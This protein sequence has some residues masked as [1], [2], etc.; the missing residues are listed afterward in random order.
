MFGIGGFEL[1]L[2]LLF[3]FLI[4][5]PDKLPEIAKIIGM[6]I[7][8]FKD[9]KAEMDGVIKEEIF[10]PSSPEPFKD[11]T[12][13]LDRAHDVVK[14]TVTRPENEESFAERKARYDRKRAEQKSRAEDDAKK[15]AEI[16]ENR[17]KMKAEAAEKAEAASEDSASSQPASED[18]SSEQTT[19]ED[20]TSS[21]AGTTFTPPSIAEVCAAAQAQSEASASATASTTASEEGEK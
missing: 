15:Q 20:S 7:G 14:S 21:Q 18:S 9:A 13:A 17:A 6:A 1:F 8:K 16:D 10:D 4:F 12:K 11:L 5:G 2:I 19:T 3:V